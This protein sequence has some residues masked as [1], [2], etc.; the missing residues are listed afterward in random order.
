M[1]SEIDS[2]IIERM[3]IALE[4]VV[5]A[6]VERVVGE[7]LSRKAVPSKL[8]TVDQVAELASVHAET[9]RRAERKGRLPSVRVLGPL[10]FRLEDVESFLVS[11]ANNSMTEY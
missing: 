7:A 1:L 10:R 9:V 11:R 3:A 4:P 8:L 5:V 2:Q 6:T